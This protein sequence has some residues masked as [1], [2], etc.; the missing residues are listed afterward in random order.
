MTDVGGEQELVRALPALQVLAVGHRPVGQRRVDQHL[1]VALGQRGGQ[2]MR[3]AE[4]PVLRPVAG[5]VGNEIGLIGQRKEVLAQLG[6]RHGFAHRHAVAHDV[7]I[8]VGEIDDGV[9]AGVLDVPGADVPLLRDRPVEHLRA[10]RH[11]AHLE[12]DVAA[13]QAERRPDAVA[14]DAA[15]DRIELRRQRIGALAGLGEVGL[16]PIGR[17]RAGHPLPFRASS[18]AAATVSMQRF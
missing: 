1:V 5:A 16:F 11:L 8:R 12:I 18:R 4:A 15:A 14:G 7:Q 3:Q 10:R 13:H 9:A 6:K 17:A 2:P